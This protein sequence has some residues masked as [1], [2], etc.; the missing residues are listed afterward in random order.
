MNNPKVFFRRTNELEPGKELNYSTLS[1]KCLF[2][3][4]YPE[5]IKQKRVIDRP[6]FKFVIHA[7][8]LK[9][10]KHRVWMV[11]RFGDVGITDNLK[12]PKGY[13]KRV[14][15]SELKNWTINKK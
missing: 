2:S 13:N 10:K 6:W 4:M 7:E 12:D 9:G 3:L 1:H 14:D 11:S 5:T 8:D 15:P